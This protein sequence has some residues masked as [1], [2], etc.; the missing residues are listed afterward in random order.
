MA[1]RVSL[2]DV[3]MAIEVIK[4]DGGVI[5]TDFSSIADV[6][7]VSSDAAPILAKLKAEVSPSIHARRRCINSIIQ[8]IDC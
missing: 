2:H 1:R 5:L 7:K 4:Q 3:E 8:E 6:E